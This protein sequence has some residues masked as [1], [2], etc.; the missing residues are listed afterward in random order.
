M[1]TSQTIS[2][3]LG[4]APSIIDLGPG[5]AG[6]G[7]SAIDWRRIIGASLREGILSDGSYA[8]TPGAGTREISIAA[9]T[10][11]GVVITGDSVT[12][13]GKYLVAPHSAAITLQHDA[14]DA[15][16][17]RNDLVV[18]EVLDSVS[19]AGGSNLARVRIITGTPNASAT[20]TDALGVNGTPT[21]P[22]TAIPLAV[23]NVDVG[24]GVLSTGDIDDRRYRTSGVK[25]ISGV[26]TTSQTA[27]FT[28]LTT[29]DEVRNVVVPT[30]HVL[31]VDYR[32]LIK[33]ASASGN[34]A[35][36]F[37]LNGTQVTSEVSDGVAV[38]ASAALG[39][40]A[41]FYSV[42]RSLAN[43]D[44]GLSLAAGSTASNSSFGNRIANYGPV[45]LDVA[46]GTYTVSVRF[47]AGTG[48]SPTL[49]VKER[50]L[51]VWVQPLVT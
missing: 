18:L 28:T 13:Q 23:V 30:N 32:A 49:S 15:T 22:S 14:A 41:A 51:R 31:M 3:S 47:K 12:A 17:P 20:V 19:D 43:Q 8:V 9:A 4:H 16:N 7:Y 36:A 46:A 1:A 34:G 39:S 11:D 2:P 50:R 10:G 38:A 27:S 37:F 24:E 40:A 26:E 35:A 33:I 48:G 6:E 21:L 5:A 45:A 44:S 25:E 42:L 29:A